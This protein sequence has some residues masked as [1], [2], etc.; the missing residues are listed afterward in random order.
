MSA[1]VRWHF[2]VLF[3]TLPGL[4]PRA[5]AQAPPSPATPS[6]PEATRRTRSLFDNLRAVQGRQ[7]LFGHQDDLAY[8]IGWKREAGRSDVQAV[9]G[10]YPAV[11][12]WDLGRKMGD[13]ILFNIDTVNFEDMRQWARKA[14]QMGGINTFSWH[15]DNPKTGKD[16]WDP[17]PAV[18]DILPGGP[19]HARLTEQ[20]DRI[21]VF[22][23]R[24]ESGGWL[25]RHKI[26]IVFRP[27]HEHTGGWFWWGANSC[28]P[29]EYRQ[30][31]R[32]TVD[33]L[34]RDKGLH[35][36]LFAY[37]PDVFTD[38]AHYM[39]NYPGDA[40][41]DILGLDYYYRQ[42]NLAQIQ[43]DLP[44]KLRLVSD[45]A[46]RH[47]KIAAFT[48]TGLESIPAEN[49][50]TQ[51]L[52]PHLSESLNPAAGSGISYVL[53]WRNARTSH[54]YAPYPGHQ[55][56]ADFVSFSKN[57]KVLL[58]GPAVKSMYKREKPRK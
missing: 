28:T 45:M 46:F 25:R 52:L 17:T 2:V 29:E 41:V 32:F 9:C 58:A 20:L 36:L 26:P 40:Y 54:H 11:F 31:Y 35:N 33:Y 16:S 13:S 51:M 23:G 34:R 39:L 38:E 50:W 10:A 7:V 14:Y 27:W 4:L 6:D 24:L 42:N 48:E 12:G 56:A 49:W 47:G 21:A 57:T 1:F 15:W 53:V 37:S 55:S 43:T 19:L 3:V 44:Q 30:L 18:A 22:F 8:G 5:F